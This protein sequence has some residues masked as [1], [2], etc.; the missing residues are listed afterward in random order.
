MPGLLSQADFFLLNSED[1]YIIFFGEGGG[2]LL[3]Q[4]LAAAILMLDDQ[5][6]HKISDWFCPTVR[7]QKFSAG[8]PY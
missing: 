5:F 8:P 6:E 1:F 4:I 3:T 2:G 7:V